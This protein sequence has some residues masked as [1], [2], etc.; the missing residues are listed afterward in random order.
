LALYREESKKIFE[1]L[2][3]YTQMVEKASCDEA[4]LDVTAEINQKYSNLLDSDQKELFNRPEGW[5]SSFFLGVKEGG[6]F[7]P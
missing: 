1:I 4:F 3:R 5:G 6:G 7:L 2:R